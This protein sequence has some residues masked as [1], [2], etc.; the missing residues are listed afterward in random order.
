MKASITKQNQRFSARHALLLAAVVIGWISCAGNGPQAQSG[1]TYYYYDGD[2]RYEIQQLPDLVAEFNS[3]GA[4]LSMDRSAT[5]IGGSGVVKIYRLSADGQSTLSRGVPATGQLSPVFEQSGMRMAL[6]GGVLI[7]LDP[8]WSDTQCRDWVIAR[9]SLVRE[10]LK[11]QGNHY[12]IASQPG[13]A[14]LSFANGLRGEPGLLSASP[15]WWR[16]VG[17]RRPVTPTGPLNNKK[18]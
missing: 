4:A 15:N 12:L 2:Q 1:S 9:G 14:G 11:I 18:P 10:K 7:S 16:E 13:L 5:A 6:P 3:P 8:S 17:P